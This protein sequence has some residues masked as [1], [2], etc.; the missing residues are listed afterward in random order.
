MLKLR[1]WVGATVR[2][3]VT[4]ADSPQGKPLW[5]VR[6]TDRETYP[7]DEYWDLEAVV[8]G[9]V[10]WKMGTDYRSGKVSSGR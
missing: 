7:E 9:L 8:S 6:F 4:K 3:Y 10:M 1:S 2:A 5:A